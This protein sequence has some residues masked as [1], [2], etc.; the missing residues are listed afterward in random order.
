LIQQKAIY[1]PPKPR[2][3]GILQI[4]LQ[5]PDEYWIELFSR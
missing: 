3:D 1:R 5:D 2:P 4:F